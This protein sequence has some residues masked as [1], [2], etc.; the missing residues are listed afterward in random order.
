VI[1]SIVYGPVPSRRLG[2]SLGINN[3]PPKRCSYSCIYCQLGRT[4]DMQIERRI[5]YDPLDIA[6]RVEDRA[7]HIREKS[8]TV[9]YV[10]LVTDGEPTLDI[11]LGIEI[12]LLRA[13]GIKIAVITNAS[14]IWLEDVRRDLQKADWVS[15][16]VDSTTPGV[17]SIINRPHGALRL[18]VIL[19][20]ITSFAQTF[21]GI[22][23]TETMLINGINDDMGEMG[24]VA[25]FLKK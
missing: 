18:D 8:E 25:D 3:I 20:G 22:L 15:I 12:E 6:R 1:S 21:E 16:K 24:Q 9:D 7:K 10:T 5:Y 19:E 11:N 14:L 17:W 4:T 2:R 23:A 13:M